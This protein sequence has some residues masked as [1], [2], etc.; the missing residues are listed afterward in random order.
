MRR[1]LAAVIVED[2]LVPALVRARAGL[3]EPAV[4]A[5]GLHRRPLRELPAQVVAG[6]EVTEPRV[7]RLHVVVLEIDLDERLP[8]VVAL[9]Q[10]DAVQQIAREIQVAERESREIARDVAR[11]VEQE[12]VPVADRRAAELRARLVLEVGCAEQLAGKVVGPAMD[13]ADDV[14]RAALAGQHDRLPVAADVGQQFDA[15]RS[16]H[17][18]LRV[19]APGENVVVAR[20]GRHQRVADVAGPLREQVPALGV[21]HPGIAIPRSRKLR[22]GLPQPR[23]SGEI[24]HRSSFHAWITNP[25]QQPGALRRACRCEVPGPLC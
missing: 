9:V 8:V 10:V 21:E 7:E 12:A 18:G 22:R 25:T 23:G 15:L 11:A 2:R 4:D 1:L 13:R 16:V 17:E 24:G 3:C 14:L 6:D 5:D 20:L 19:V